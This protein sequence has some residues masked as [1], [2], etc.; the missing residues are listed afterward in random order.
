MSKDLL[1]ERTFQIFGIVMTIG[2]FVFLRKI[3]RQV[4]AESAANPDHRRN[5]D[6]ET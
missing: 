4:R 1:I 2:L 6:D 3:L 5:E